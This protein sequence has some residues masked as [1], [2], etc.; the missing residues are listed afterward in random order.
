MQIW[1]TLQGVQNLSRGKGMNGVSVSVWC[2]K[3]FLAIIRHSDNINSL[4]YSDGLWFHM[5][6][7]RLFS[8]MNKTVLTAEW[9]H[10]VLPFSLSLVMLL[11]I[12]L[13]FLISVTHEKLKAH[14]QWRPRGQGDSSNA[15]LTKVK[16]RLEICHTCKRLCRDNFHIFRA[17]ANSK[18][19]KILQCSPDVPKQTFCTVITAALIW[20]MQHSKDF[21]RNQ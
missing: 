12:Y 2:H 8:Y 15:P 7:S 1:G 6:T 19:N 10:N 17:T 16:G 18:W 20:W 13:V 3:N 5:F 21:N 14:A 11:K 4:N 9:Y